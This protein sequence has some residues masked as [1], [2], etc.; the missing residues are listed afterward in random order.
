[1]REGSLKEGYSLSILWLVLTLF[2]VKVTLLVLRSGLSLSSRVL[3]RFL[4]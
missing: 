3:F 2:F 4:T 1:M